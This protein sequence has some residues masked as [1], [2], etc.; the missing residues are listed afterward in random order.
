MIERILRTVYSGKICVFNLVVLELRHWVSKVKHTYRGHRILV[1]SQPN[2]FAVT[3]HIY[4]TL[5]KDTNIYTGKQNIITY[6]VVILS[7][8]L[9]ALLY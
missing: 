4:N 9:F 5:Q 7:N 1:L 8:I 3:H 6:E 2:A